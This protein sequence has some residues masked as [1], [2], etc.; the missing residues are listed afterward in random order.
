MPASSPE[1]APVA[2]LH[3]DEPFPLSI[4]RYAIEDGLE[5][6]L[7]PAF[8]PLLREVALRDFAAVSRRLREWA[9]APRLVLP[10]PVAGGVDT[11]ARR[12]VQMGLVNF[13]FFSDADGGHRWILA[14]AL[15][16]V[17]AIVLPGRIVHSLPRHRIAVRKALG[18]LLLRERT[19][20]H[21][22]EG[23]A[24]FAGFLVSHKTPFHFFYDLL[25]NVPPLVDAAQ[26]AGKALYHRPE[27]TFFPLAAIAGGVPVRHLDE[28]AGAVVVYPAT[29][30]Q[31]DLNALGL[32]YRESVPAA[33]PGAVPHAQG[34]LVSAAMRALETRIAGYA[35]EGAAPAAPAPGALSL[36]IGI[37]DFK[38][39]WKQQVEGFASL[40]GWLHAHV[41]DLEVVFDGMTAPAGLRVESPSETAVVDAIRALLPAPVRVTSLVGMDYPGKIRVG[42]RVDAFVCDA[43]TA[44]LVPLRFCGKP[45]VMFSNGHIHS[46][47][48][49]YAQPVAM[50]ERRLVV[51]D[52]DTTAREAQFKS[53]H[54]FWKDVG[55]ALVEV[56]NAAQSRALPPLPVPASERRAFREALGLAAPAPA[57]GASP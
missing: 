10:H 38:R 4:G 47:P 11:E 15:N 52:G 19:L 6:A 25:K 12:C 18:D 35:L 2:P 23:A 26:A 48:D 41:P 44:A 57:E 17:D 27:Q 53:V 36:W 5:V 32:V 22:F 33:R 1:P 8:A 9:A 46:F 16:L 30:Q 37:S 43:G 21:L 55:A 24:P 54:I 20:V 50:L 13:V 56:L 14:Q 39:S 29:I 28:A 3:H 31:N 7:A 42:R 51:P 49:R 40:I 34:P 45:G